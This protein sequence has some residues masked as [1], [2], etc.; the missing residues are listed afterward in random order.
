MEDAL[1]PQ[2][3]KVEALHCH[4]RDRVSCAR[5]PDE[6]AMLLSPAALKIVGLHGEGVLD[7][8]QWSDVTEYS[9][10]HHGNDASNMEVFQFS[11][12][13]HGLLQFECNAAEAFLHAFEVCLRGMD[14]T[15]DCYLCFTWQ[16]PS[17]SLPEEVRSSTDPIHRNSDKPCFAFNA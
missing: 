10:F 11:V 6:V 12:F 5:Y 16:D 1:Q 8:I 17:G 15:H 3:D 7:T 14:A 4:P 9:A 13:E 2:L